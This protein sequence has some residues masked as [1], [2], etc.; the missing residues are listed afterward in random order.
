MKTRE[1]ATSYDKGNTSGNNIIS[2]YGLSEIQTGTPE[3]IS[4]YGPSDV[5]TAIPEIKGSDYSFSSKVGSPTNINSMYDA[6]AY[7]FSSKAAAATNINSMYDEP[8]YDPKPTSTSESSEENNFEFN[9]DS[10]S[11]SEDEDLGVRQSHSKDFQDFE[12]MRDLSSGVTGVASLYQYKGNDA[13]ISALTNN[14]GMLVVKSLGSTLAD[15]NEGKHAILTFENERINAEL[16][17]N[18]NNKPGLQRPKV[19]A[20]ANEKGNFILN[21]CIYSNI[22]N[23]KSQSLEAYAVAL[24]MNPYGS[25]PVEQRV[26]E[27][28]TIFQSMRESI[29]EMHQNGMIHLDPGARNFMMT[30]DGKVKVIDFGTSLP[31]NP[32]TQVS[33]KTPEF[34]F[35]PYSLY[36]QAALQSPSVYSVYTDSF[37]LKASMMELIAI[38]LGLPPDIRMV[39]Q[40]HLQGLN[41][42]QWQE[43]PV[44]L[45]SI[46]K[47]EEIDLEKMKQISDEN[48]GKPILIRHRGE[49]KIFG[50]SILDSNRSEDWK[51]TNISLSSSRRFSELEFSKNKLILK[52]LYPNE[53]PNKQEISALS[54]KEGGMPVLIKSDGDPSNAWMYRY[55]ATAKDWK[56]EKL[57]PK[58]KDYV[59][60]NIKFNDPSDYGVMGDDHELEKL[61]QR[62]THSYGQLFA[63]T[64]IEV[65]IPY[66]GQI[67]KSDKE[68]ISEKNG[69]REQ[70]ATQTLTHLSDEQ[71]LEL[72]FRNLKTY[73]ENHPVE[74]NREVALATLNRYEN[75]LKSFPVFDHPNQFLQHDE[76]L[77][78]ASKGIDSYLVRFN[79]F[80]DDTMES[81]KKLDAD[82]KNNYP[83]VK[84]DLFQLRQI[85][86]YLK[87]YPNSTLEQLT[88]WTKQIKV[89]HENLQNHQTPKHENILSDKNTQLTTQEK[90]LNAIDFLIEK[91]NVLLKTQKN[92][93]AFS[94]QSQKI[95]EKDLVDLQNLRK[96][97][98][99]DNKNDKRK[100][101]SSDKVDLKNIGERIIKVAR[102]CEPAKKEELSSRDVN[103]PHK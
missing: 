44:V 88:E 42:R 58:D 29:N 15:T 3:I 17:S 97:F 81:L 102:A 103:S 30:P 54:K 84:Q 53:I 60:K 73:A 77:F 40:I 27:I 86:A 48:D 89:V 4:M 72:S 74:V 38:Y 26:S 96:A 37:A 87:T 70:N 83:N 39:K 80:L 93:P 59:M 64:K 5:K 34:L 6:P 52:Q 25:V 76:N 7:T 82:P 56:L 50:N 78:K 33:I 32:N 10:D 63:P 91:A 13:K 94:E 68:Y 14:Q 85:E 55:S 62:I 57:K 75:Y 66:T 8:G 23:T 2:L 90:T 46:N 65:I 71:R 51:I 61:H 36:N 49:I 11:E 31:I 43:P 100:S 99:Q 41:M 92:N 19:L 45:I 69:H 20:I 9:L 18:W 1:I 16:L 22:E 67:D 21:E 28:G 24:G 47:N 35:K 12:F 95:M 101:A 79:K 98:E